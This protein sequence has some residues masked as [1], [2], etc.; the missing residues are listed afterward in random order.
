MISDAS[1]FAESP[2]GSGSQACRLLEQDLPC[3]SRK[4]SAAPLLVMTVPLA[5]AV[6]NAAGVLLY[7]CEACDYPAEEPATEWLNADGVEA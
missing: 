6:A 3:C 5:A 2:A 7:R 1:P 4:N